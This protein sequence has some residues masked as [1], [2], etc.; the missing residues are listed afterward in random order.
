M[1]IA[2]DR[3]QYV[4]WAI[5]REILPEGSTA[6]AFLFSTAHA[7]HSSKPDSVLR[8]APFQMQVVKRSSHSRTCRAWF[9][10][11]SSTLMTR[12]SPC[13]ERA[14][15]ICFMRNASMPA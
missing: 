14:G 4:H 8:E 5:L 3:G 15:G 1:E 7:F 10:K 2:K 12:N 9:A 11:S 13:F 6:Q